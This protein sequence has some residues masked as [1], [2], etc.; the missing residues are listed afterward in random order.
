MF[1]IKTRAVKV[2]EA[3]EKG[4]LI[5]DVR[6]P[7]EYSDGHIKNS[8]NIPLQ[9]MDSRIAMLKKKNNVLITCCGSGARSG[10]A[11]SV[12]KKNGVECINGGGWGNLNYLLH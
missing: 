11:C 9:Q 3:L 1:G 8:I 2:A 5:V 7:Q 6:T 4:A 10:R 12:L